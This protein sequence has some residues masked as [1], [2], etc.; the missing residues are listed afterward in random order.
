MSDH[1]MMLVDVDATSSQA[2]GVARAVLDRFRN[3]GLITG[4]ANPDCV[5]GGTGYRP[6]HAVAE[7]YKCGEHETPFWKYRTCGVEPRVGRDF[8]GWALN[9]SDDGLIC[10]ACGA[11][12][13]GDAAL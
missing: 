5:L 11:A 12:P 3:L 1:F 9:L 4:D 10:P 7:L 8:N 2:G 6:G 13:F